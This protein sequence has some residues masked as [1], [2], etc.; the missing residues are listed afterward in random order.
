VRISNSPIDAFLD[1]PL[2][3]GVEPIPRPDGTGIRVYVGPRRKGVHVHMPAGEQADQVIAT[4][5]GERGHLFASEIDRD[6]LCDCDAAD[7]HGPTS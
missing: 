7:P 5:C 6:Q 1:A 4:W 2:V 3:T